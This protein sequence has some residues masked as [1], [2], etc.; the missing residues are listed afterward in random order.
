MHFRKPLKDLF[1]KTNLFIYLND[2][3]KNSIVDE[4]LLQSHEGFSHGSAAS[5]TQV[6]RAVLMMAANDAETARHVAQI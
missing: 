5:D 6:T 2:Y 1:S 4:I 3:R